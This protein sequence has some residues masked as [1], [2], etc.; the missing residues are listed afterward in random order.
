MKKMDNEETTCW[1]LCDGCEWNAGDVSLAR[2]RCA[3]YPGAPIE[4]RKRVMSSRAEPSDV[5]PNAAPKTS[6]VT[7]EKVLRVHGACRCGVM[8]AKRLLEWAEGDLSIAVECAQHLGK[9][10]SVTDG[11]GNKIGYA[12]MRA[13][14]LLAEKKGGRP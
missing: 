4:T 2:C 3:K 12:E 14:M 5:C 8:R 9:C 1:Y 6:D 11:G 10:V 13:E 7:T